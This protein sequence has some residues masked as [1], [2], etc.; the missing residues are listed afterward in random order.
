MPDHVHMLVEVDPQFG[1][2]PLVKNIK[3]VSI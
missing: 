1:I 3:G 2:H